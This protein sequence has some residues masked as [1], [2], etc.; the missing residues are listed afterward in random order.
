[1]KMWCRRNPLPTA[2]AGL[3]AMA[4]LAGFAGVT[5]KW[6][7]ADRQ[8]INAATV[9]ELLTKRILAQASPELQPRGA[10]VTVVELLDRAGAQLG[11]WLDGQ[12]EVEAAVHETIGGAY[13]AL[14]QYDNT[15]KHLRAAV[16]LFSRLAG[17]EHR[18]TLRAGNLMAALL[19]ETGRRTE[20][21]PLCR[22]NLATCRRMLGPADEITLDAS[23]RLGL[24]LWHCG[25]M[26]EAET[27]L[28]RTLEDRKRML[29][30]DHPDTLGSMYHLCRVLRQRGKY[31][32]ADPLAYQ[33]AHDIRC[34]RGPNHPDNVSALSNQAD[35][36]FDQARRELAE[37]TYQKAVAEAKRIL[38]AEHPATLAVAER[39]ARFLRE[40]RP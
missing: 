30:Q 36:Y 3:L 8:R 32:E 6:R 11:G 16:G 25:K 9:N 4:V 15:E 13:L 14:A 20:A 23:E 1:M 37:R 10:S 28:R 26:D 27:Q 21:E 38:G 17:P 35:L 18:D 12:P 29:K 40:M 19:D 31:A 22:S 5:W 34:A 39:H 33:Y 2:L 7:E 24:L